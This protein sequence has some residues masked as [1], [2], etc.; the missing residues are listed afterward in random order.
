ML[1]RSSN[2]T[3]LQQRQVQKVG[4][5]LRGRKMVLS[6][7]LLHRRVYLQKLILPPRSLC[8]P[9]GRKLQ[10]QLMLMATE[11]DTKLQRVCSPGV[12]CK[13]TLI[14]HLAVVGNLPPFLIHEYPLLECER[15][16]Q[17]SQTA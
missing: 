7:F 9:K 4:K 15:T 10:L 8:L 2:V 1:K 12:Q 17:S 3:K 11:E 16:Q 6:N 13:E 5:L 14:D